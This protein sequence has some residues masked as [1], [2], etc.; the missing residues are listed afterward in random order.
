[1][2]D[3]RHSHGVTSEG[4]LWRIFTEHK[5]YVSDRLEH[6]LL[7]Y[8]SALAR[9]ITRGVPVRLLEIGAQI[10]GSLQIWSKYLPADSIIVGIDIDPTC[11][12]LTWGVNVIAMTWDASD[13]VA[14]DRMLGDAY[15][16]V[17]IDNGSRR[18]EHVI[19]TFEACFDRLNPGGIYVVEDLHASYITSPGGGFRVPG[20]LMEWFKGMLDGLNADHYPNDTTEKLD[21]S[22]LQHIRNRGRQIA[23]VSFFASVVLLEKQPSQRQTPYRRI[24][25]G[26]MAPC[27]A[28]T[29]HV[30][31]IA[32][33]TA[34]WASAEQRELLLPPFT[35]TA[36][37]PAMLAAIAFDRKQAEHAGR[38]AE[39]R[40]TRAEQAR[41]EVEKQL[42]QL[43]GRATMWEARARESERARERIA[44]RITGAR[45]D[46]YVANL[47]A[48]QAEAQAEQAEARAERAELRADQAE[49]IRDAILSSTAWQATWPL[50]MMA[51]KSPLWMRK[52]LHATARLGWRFFTLNLPHKLRERRAIL[53]H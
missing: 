27:V 43:R 17:I 3:R 42:T 9:F 37:T 51:N 4:T 24:I 12:Q 40:A 53:R 28:L 5:G 7:I 50:R 47:H 34:V 18:A 26:S 46:V 25:T 20:T 2:C 22:S 15:F 21:A 16:D 1:M 8:E 32:Q 38:A 36:L 31:S 49:A 10:G 11:A 44:L 30:I 23:C 14:L 48:E 19:A 13:L 52:A 6:Y 33:G 35:A 39:V 45:R 29:S 41:K